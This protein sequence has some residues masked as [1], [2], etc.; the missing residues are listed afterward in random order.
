M[1]A[2]IFASRA[3]STNAKTGAVAL[4]GA[5]FMTLALTHVSA[6][7]APLRVLTLALAAFATWAFCD[8]MGMRKP[9]NRAAFVF[10][11]IAVVAKVQI[12]LG[13]T[14]EF[15]GRYYL[16]YAAFLLMAVLLWSVAFLHRQRA[17]K[18][19]GALG[20]VA[21]AFPIAAIVIGHLVVGVGAAIGVSALLAATEGSAAPDLGFV[22][23]VERIFGLWAYVAAWL[24]W[25]GHVAAS[26]AGAISQGKGLIEN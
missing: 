2:S 6:A 14:A 4:A 3:E 15:E 17:L 21:T 23:L 5:A 9:L 12:A 16:L 11:T 22:T 10:F 20:V 8:E 19:V 1:S 25:R 13:L 7:L 18:V 26:P 24:L